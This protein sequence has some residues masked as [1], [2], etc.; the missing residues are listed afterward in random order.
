MTNLSDSGCDDKSLLVSYLYEECGDADRARAE[1]HLAECA[2]CRDELEALTGVR[3]RLANWAPPEPSPEFRV[4]PADAVAVPR[5]PWTWWQSAPVWSLAAAAVFLVA[6]SV[7]NLEIRYGAD[8]LVVR[9][10][11]SEAAP[12]QTADVAD[13]AAWEA[14]LAALEADLRR[15]FSAPAADATSPAATDST[16]ETQPLLTRVQRLI[17]ESERRQQRD[18][19][20]RFAQLMREAEVQRQADLLRIEEQVGQL[21]GLTEAEVVQHNEIMDYLVRVAG[22]PGQRR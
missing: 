17:E 5:R 11:W 15:E 2:T 1:T 21:E 9:T 3:G 10:G 7:A 19:A 6:A 14:D 4:V 20:L 18:V 22:Q 8:G 12:S 13:D 16:P